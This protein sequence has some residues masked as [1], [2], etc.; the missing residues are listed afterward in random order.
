[1]KTTTVLL[2]LAALL[3]GCATARP[4][5]YPINF[6]RMASGHHVEKFWCD[7]GSIDSPP[8]RRCCLAG[9]TRAGVSKT[10]T[11]CRVTMARRGSA[12]LSWSLARIRS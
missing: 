10:R 2:L 8:I 11:V 12:R 7:H 1:M 5:G 4:S 3:S 9:S 6:E